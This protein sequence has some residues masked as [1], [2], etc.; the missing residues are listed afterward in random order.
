MERFRSTAADRWRST[1]R[2]TSGRGRHPCRPSPTGATAGNG[3]RRWRVFAMA[4]SIRCRANG[5]A[6]IRRISSS[7]SSKGRYRPDHG[8]SGRSSAVSS[9]RVCG[10]RTNGIIRGYPARS[11]PSSPSVSAS[12]AGGEKSSLGQLPDSLS[13]SDSGITFD[14]QPPASSSG[15]IVLELRVRTCGCRPRVVDWQ[16]SSSARRPFPLRP[17]RVFGAGLRSTGSSSVRGDS[18]RAGGIRAVRFLQVALAARL[19]PD[20][21]RHPVRGSVIASR[22]IRRAIPDRTPSRL[23]SMNSSLLFS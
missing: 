21:D 22:R 20:S 7:T 14:S 13:S 18:W 1:A 19:R 8:W 16:S 15:R 2:S 17:P 5:M 3:M 11:A 6:S 12:P 9:C 4:W 10:G 23:V